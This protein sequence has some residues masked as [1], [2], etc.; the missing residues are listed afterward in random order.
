MEDLCSVHHLWLYERD[1][2]QLLGQHLQTGMYDAAISLSQAVGER[3]S[4][5]A[6]DPL[7]LMWI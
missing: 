4:W 5:S 1:F 2:F 3:E 7:G 6:L